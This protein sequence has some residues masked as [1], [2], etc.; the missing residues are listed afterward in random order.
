MALVFGI[1]M[2]I[3]EI[4]FVLMVLLLAGLVVVVLELRRLATLIRT[5]KAELKRFELDLA[6]F[7]RDQGKKPSAA[8]ISYI[9]DAISKGV[10]KTA[11]EYELSKAGWSKNEIDTIFDQLK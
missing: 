1:D 9:D 8:M 4:I 2:P 3:L 10:S 7:E 6:Q 11:V 5:E